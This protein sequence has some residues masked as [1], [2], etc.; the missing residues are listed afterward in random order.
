LKL[1]KKLEK[2]IKKVLHLRYTFDTP[3][4]YADEKIVLD[5]GVMV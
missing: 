3:N 2:N 4:F 5:I 1:Q